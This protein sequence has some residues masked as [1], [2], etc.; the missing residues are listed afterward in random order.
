[1]PTEKE[2]FVPQDNT[3][4]VSLLYGS[5]YGQFKVPAGATMGEVLADVQIKEQIGYGNLNDPNTMLIANGELVQPDYVVK[6][7]DDLEIIKRAGEK[8]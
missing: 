8:A 3:T 4:S 2:Q 6:E 7:N 1:M 5:S